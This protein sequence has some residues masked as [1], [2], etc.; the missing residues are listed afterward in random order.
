MNLRDNKRKIVSLIQFPELQELQNQ[1]DHIKNLYQEKTDILNALNIE[2]ISTEN[3]KEFKPDSQKTPGKTESVKNQD[4][5]DIKVLESEIVTLESEPEIQIV[6]EVPRPKLDLKKYRLGKR[7]T[8]MIENKD[9]MVVEV[10]THSETPGVTESSEKSD[11][12]ESSEKPGVTEFSDSI[13][14]DEEGNT[15]ESDTITSAN[16]DCELKMYCYESVVENFQTHM[17]QMEID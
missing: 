16:T 4:S 12:T 14:S 7:K 11:I 3:M 8:K 5:E 2:T 9:V 13:A 6:D 10:E 15:S 17:D 1:L